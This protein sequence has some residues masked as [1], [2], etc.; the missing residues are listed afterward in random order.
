MGRLKERKIIATLAA[1]AGSGV[2][3]IE[4]AH[5]IL[6]NHYHFPHQ[7]VDICIVTLSGA[8]LS[9][10]IWRWFRGTEKRPRNVKVEVLVVP[11]VILLTLVIDLKLIFTM[12]GIS[13]NMLIIGIVALGLGGIAWVIFKSLQWA[14][15]VSEVGRKVDVLKPEEEK[16][17]T[18]AGVRVRPGD[19]IVGDDDGVIVVPQEMVD[20]VARR[21]KLVQ[22]TD[23]PGRRSNYEKLG[24]PL[25]ETIR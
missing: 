15:S 6:V 2:I 21:A 5:H 17:I 1:F 3:I 7:T 10:V 25:D 22:D 13:I 24:L 16:L 9:T 18:F 23:R 8:L 12:T 14:A 19:V 20:E 4:L 11:L